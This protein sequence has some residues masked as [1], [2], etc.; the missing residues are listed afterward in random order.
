MIQG[1]GLQAGVPGSVMD[2][3]LK[4]FACRLECFASPLNSR[5]DQF[6]S[7]FPDVD[8]WFGSVGSFFDRMGQQQSLFGM[9]AAKNND[10]HDNGV[11]YQ[12]NPPFCDGLILLLNDSISKVL[13][14]ANKELPTMFVVFVPAWLDASCY[15]SLLGNEYLVKHTL[16]KQG[17]HFYAE[18][19]RHRRKDSFRVASFDTSI[20]FY[21]N[22]AA[23]LKWNL[24]PD[25]E[26]QCDCAVIVELKLA[27]CQDP[28]V[29]EEEKRS[30]PRKGISKDLKQVPIHVTAPI[31]EKDTLK[32][33]VDASPTKKSRKRKNDSDKTQTKKEKKRQWSEHGEDKNQ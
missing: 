21:Q 13:S 29:M 33:K 25:S 26:S 4:H 8:Q 12:A 18:G 19:T 9:D 24:E 3:L 1:A 14:I 11:C 10:M 5:Y 23:K 17:Q 20:L 27:F 30:M 16:L 2:T 6:C 32:S 7:A 15:Q 31:S 28:S 22:D